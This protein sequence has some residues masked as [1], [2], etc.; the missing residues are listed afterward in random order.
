MEYAS[1]VW[2]PHLIKHINALE[3]VQKR[4][5]KRIPSVSH[6]SYPERLAALNLE[7]LELRRLKSDLLLYYKCFHNLVELPANNYFNISHSASQTR[8]GGNRII[9]PMCNTDRFR[10]DFFNRCITCWNT[11]PDIVV[12]ANSVYHFKR[13]LNNIDLSSFMHCSYF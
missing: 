2:S 13:L 6:M 4:F 12:N 5:T 10:N 8:T 1:N 3:R 9:V 11:L 7:P